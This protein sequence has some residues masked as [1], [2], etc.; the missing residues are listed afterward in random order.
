MR[1]PPLD[2]KRLSYSI[3][4]KQPHESEEFTGRSSSKLSSSIQ[5]KSERK[6]NSPMKLH[7]ILSLSQEDCLKFVGDVMSEISR[8]EVEGERLRSRTIS[9]KNIR[10]SRA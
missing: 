6:P 10:I 7:K 8:I 3:P 1:I 9:L 4:L 5:V 2:T